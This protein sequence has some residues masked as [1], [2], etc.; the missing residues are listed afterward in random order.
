[1]YTD[2]S[3][4]FIPQRLLLP[5]I[6]IISLFFSNMQYVY[7]YEALQSA[8]LIFAFRSIVFHDL[9]HTRRCANQCIIITWFQFDYFHVIL[10]Q[11]PI[12]YS[13]F[14]TL[15]LSVGN[16]SNLAYWKHVC[17]QYGHHI[18]V[19]FIIQIGC[20]S[21]IFRDHILNLCL[22]S[23]TNVRQITSLLRVLCSGM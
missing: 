17:F 2:S 14:L 6:P 21:A 16:L 4:P 9:Q 13:F 3:T 11:Q 7:Y 12:K 19:S 10:Q 22:K 8:H 20:H 1:M 5:L 15:N 18:Y 23:R